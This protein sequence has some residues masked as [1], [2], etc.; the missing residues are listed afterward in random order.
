MGD[1]GVDETAL[2]IRLMCRYFV[3]VCIQNMTCLLGHIT[4]GQMIPNDAGKMIEKW[5]FELENKF[6]DIKCDTHIIMPNH[7]HCII[8]NLGAIRR[9]EPMC[10]P[11]IGEQ[12]DADDAGRT[13]EPMCS[14]FLGE[15]MFSPFLGEHTA[16]L[17]EHKG[18]PLHR[19]MQWFGTMTTNEY[20]RG[21]KTLGWKRFDKKIW[22]RNYWENIIRN[23]KSYHRISNY[24]VNNPKKLGQR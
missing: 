11:I 9:G 19:V 2:F 21:V 10:S 8:E 22:H 13:G 5:Y 14:P 1:L 4:D 24:I 15:P 12:I 16:N 7:F 23:E 18:S 6:P 3:T 20:I 17:G